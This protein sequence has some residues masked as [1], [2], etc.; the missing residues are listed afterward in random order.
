MRAAASAAA[1][2]VR[3]SEADGRRSFWAGPAAL[4]LAFCSIHSDAVPRCAVLNAFIDCVLITETIVTTTPKASAA[5]EAAGSGDAISMVVM[6]PLALPL[7]CP[8]V[9]GYAQRKYEV[10][11]EYLEK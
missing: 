1:C 6:D 5:P 8:C 11:G 2:S 3:S 10:L 4:A 9:A 7:S